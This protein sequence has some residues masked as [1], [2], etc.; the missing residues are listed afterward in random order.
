M[1]NFVKIKISSYMQV[2]KEN[3]FWYYA[4]GYT[5]FLLPVW[6]K[7]EK[8]IEKIFSK[9][10]RDEILEVEKRVAYYCKLRGELRI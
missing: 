5:N 9:L 8:R 3:K 7:A 10:S 4:R 1:I 6:E 2:V